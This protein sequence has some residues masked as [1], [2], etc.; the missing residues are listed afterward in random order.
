VYGLVAEC[1]DNGSECVVCLIA[2]ADERS[3]EQPVNMLDALLPAF[4]M[5]N[6]LIVD[7]RACSPD[8]HVP[9]MLSM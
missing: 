1:L 4:L 3:V 2:R 6:Q 8:D 9:K 7:M 5:V